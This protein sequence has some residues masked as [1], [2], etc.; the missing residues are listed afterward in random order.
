MQEVKCIGLDGRVGAAH[1]E[2]LI[3]GWIAIMVE[4]Y[5]SFKVLSVN[6][7]VGKTFTMAT[8]LYEYDY[9]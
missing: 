9:E 8:I 2:T 7:V 4:G 1:I 6:I 5:N 3:N